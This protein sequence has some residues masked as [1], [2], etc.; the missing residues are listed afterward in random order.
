MA[1]ARPDDTVLELAVLMART[2]SPIVA[3][4]EGHQLMGCVTLSRVLDALLPPRST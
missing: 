3:I 4:V 2:H 1:V